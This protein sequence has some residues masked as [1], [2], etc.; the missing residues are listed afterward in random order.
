[1]YY[2]NCSQSTEERR[3]LGKVV[4]VMKEGLVPRGFQL[5]LEAERS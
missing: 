1:M 4:V 2:I 3:A 5:S